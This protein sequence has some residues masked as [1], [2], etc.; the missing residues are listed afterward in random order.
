MINLTTTQYG[1]L[2]A[3][4][5]NLCMTANDKQTSEHQYQLSLLADQ[6]A[7]LTGELPEEQTCRKA[8][9]EARILEKSSKTLEEC[10]DSANKILALFIGQFTVNG[11]PPTAN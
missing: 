1:I 6:V 2:R 10:M 5:H 11:Q 8:S 4:A 7:I 3:S 9:E